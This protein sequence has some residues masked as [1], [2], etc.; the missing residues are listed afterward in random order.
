MFKSIL[1]S[2]LALFLIAVPVLAAYSASIQV[3]TSTTYTMLPIMVTMGNDNLATYNYT[4]STGLDTRVQEEETDLP[5]MLADDKTIFA[6]TVASGSTSNFTYV[7]EE[8]ALD[9][10]YLMTGYGGKITIEDHADLELGDDFEIELDDVYVDTDSGTSKNLVSKTDSFLLYVSDD[11]EISAV[12]YP[13]IYYTPTGFVDPDTQWTDEANAYDNNTGT[14]STEAAVGI[15]SW[16]SYLELTRSSTLS[17]AVRYYADIGAYDV[18]DL[19]DVDV[20]YTGAWHDVYQGNF[21]EDTWEEKLI[22]A[23]AQFITAARV[24][25]YNNNAGTQSAELNELDLDWSPRVVATGVSSGEMDIRVEGTGTNILIYIDDVEEDSASQETA[26]CADNA[27]AWTIMDNTTTHFVSYAGY[28][29]HTVNDDVEV[30]YNP[31]EIVTNTEA[32][33]VIDSG[34]DVT[35]VDAALTQVDDYWNY[36]RL[37]ITDTTDDL[38]PEG[39]T[40][41]ITDFVAGTDTLH[42]AALT[43]AVEAADTY[44]VEFGTIPTDALITLVPDGAGDY[45]NIDTALPDVAHWQ[46]VDDPVGTPDDA[47]TRVYMNSTLQQKDIYAITDSATTGTINYVEVYFRVTAGLVSNCYAQPFLRLSAVET[48]GTRTLITYIFATWGTLS[49]VLARP[50]GGDWSWTDI[51]SLQA[52]IG[53]DSVNGTHNTQCTQLYIEV[54]YTPTGTAKQ[55][56]ITW[57]VN[58]GDVTET[59][60]NIASTITTVATT[61]PTP[62]DAF[63]TGYNTDLWGMSAPTN[64]FSP[65]VESLA[66]SIGITHIAMWIGLAMFIV[67]LFSIILYISFKNVEVAAAIGGFLMICFAVIGVLPKWAVIL[68]IIVY[69][70]P[71]LTSKRV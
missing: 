27:N 35:L 56:I 39:E 70:L 14:F 25:F 28:Y 54:N 32:T 31:S 55:G 47:T 58:P 18:N 6:A 65:I 1:L 9:D 16:S 8:S 60:S 36:A 12:M 42:F 34:S 43:A 68:A 26:S 71:V 61:T 2:L 17:N 24:R 69:F 63:P 49:E 41:I 22:P 4:S 20:Y 50:G 30:W 46:N 5:H 59:I 51:D 62:Q 13:S 37:T 10:F 52:G 57:G 11:Q 66:D 64:A 23:G 15:N 67:L 3:A 19:I 7:T 44:E 45:T 29:K 21:A 38:A 33:G 40:A 48:E 53:L